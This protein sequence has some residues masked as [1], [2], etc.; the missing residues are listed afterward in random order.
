M[1]KNKFWS[2]MR[3]FAG[4]NI[5]YALVVL[6]FCSVFASCVKDEEDTIDFLENTTGNQSTQSTNDSNI[7]SLIEKKVSIDVSYKNFMINIDIKSAL[8]AALPGKTIKYGIEYGYSGIYVW[9]QLCTNFSDGYGSIQSYLFFDQGNYAFSQDILYAKAYIELR[10]QMANGEKLSSDEKDLYD[11][12]V[13]H[14]SQDE[15]IA[16]REYRARFF[17][18]VNGKR[19]Y[20][21]EIYFN[22]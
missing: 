4:Q 12:C 10:D 19:Y 22:K 20:T 8:T 9:E 3:M 1:K 5:F 17:V 14:L 6:T 7:E 11:A 13:K 15:P 16:Q 18:E 2:M 21:N